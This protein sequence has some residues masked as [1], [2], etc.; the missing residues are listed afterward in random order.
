MSC[1]I[2]KNAEHEWFWLVVRCFQIYQCG[3]CWQPCYVNHTKQYTF[4]RFIFSDGDLHNASVVIPRCVVNWFVSCFTFT[5]II[6]ITCSS[7]TLMRGFLG[8]CCTELHYG[9]ALLCSSQETCC[10][11]SQGSNTFDLE[12][13][14]AMTLHVT[15]KVVLWWSSIMVQM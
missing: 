13:D 5:W 9:Y 7:A 10:W 12:I 3:Y 15:F 14:L 4:R 1:S 6:D 2:D 8:I 11:S